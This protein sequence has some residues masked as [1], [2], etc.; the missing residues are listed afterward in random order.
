MEVLLISGPE[1]SASCL[2]MRALVMPHDSG[3]ATGLQYS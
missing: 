3:S 2:M 1:R